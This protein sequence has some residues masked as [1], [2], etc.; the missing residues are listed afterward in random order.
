M[1]QTTLHSPSESCRS[2]KVTFLMLIFS[3]SLY[4]LS[5][6]PPLPFARQQTVSPSSKN[7]WRSVFWLCSASLSVTNDLYNYYKDKHGKRILASLVP[8]QWR[9]GESDLVNIA[10]THMWHNYP[11]V[12]DVSKII[13]CQLYSR[14]TK[15]NTHTK[16]TTQTA[17]WVSLHMCAYI[18]SGRHTE[19]MKAR[20]HN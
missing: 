1:T 4:C 7:T 2:T 10:F 6:T 20:L 5:F 9:G 16:Q 14:Y 3:L 18:V 13:Q 19:L 15:Y 17:K 11:N 12:H 8:S